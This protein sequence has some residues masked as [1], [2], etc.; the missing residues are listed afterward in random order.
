[1]PRDPQTGLEVLETAAPEE[2]V[3]E[4][5]SGGQTGAIVKA[6]G[7][8]LS[9][10]GNIAMDP[11]QT[12]ELLA[13]MQQMVDDRSGAGSQFMRGLERASAW[14]SGGAEGPARALTAVNAQQQAED[15]SLFNMRQQMA[16]LKSAAAQQQAY[17]EEQ[18]RIFGGAGKPGA[19]TGTMGI[20]AAQTYKG[21]QLDP[22]VAV[23]MGQARTREER[24][25][26]FNDFASKRSQ[27]RGSFEFGA[28]TYQTSIKF[29]RPDGRLE[30][31]DAATAKKYKDMG[32]GDYVVN[33]PTAVA[34]GRVP[35]EA[36]KQVESGGRPGLVSSAGAE[37]T[38]QVMPNTQKNPGYGV[39]PARDNSQQELERVGRD[40]YSAMQKQYGNDTLAS[41][42]YNMGPG[43]TD[44]WLKKG[45]NFKDLPQE[46]RDYIGQV[47]LATAKLNRA[48]AETAALQ[49][50]AATAPRQRMTIPEAEI[51]MESQKQQGISA[52]TAEGKY[53]GNQAATVREAGNTSGERLSS[54]QYLDGLINNPE[55]SRVF[56]VF[57]KPGF[58]NGIGNVIQKGVNLGRLGDVGIKELDSLVVANMKNATQTEIDAAQK[59]T[60]E[61]AKIK[62]NEAK[63]LLAG[64]GAV[65]DAERGLIQE[66]SG[67]RMNSP[68]A[69]RDYLAWGKMRAEYDRDVGKAYQTYR[70]QNRGGTF[71]N[72]LDTGV[73]DD[74]RDAYNQKLMDFGAKTGID[75]N[76]AAAAG[77]QQPEQ[78]KAAPQ[79][80][81]SNDDY[82]AWKKSKG[83]K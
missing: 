76:K 70:R 57:Q 33:P 44:S 37:G 72:F 9:P 51:A 5:A 81:Y 62:L 52:A 3:N 63:I 68:G 49:P 43:A 65:S 82:A 46:T 77:G 1:M 14:G 17:N 13:N 25:K 26:I 60:R 66:L 42:A 34:P 16:A 83:L 54:I 20:G 59:A 80:K 50:T 61:F 45:G 56:G 40:Y 58:M 67:S 2:A 15:T 8:G 10:V 35:P 74:L 36:I 6:T 32:Y 31:I 22:E 11:T 47:H 55:T 23:A 30:Y 12:A 28:P 78:P 24:D 71:E 73:A 19:T 41:I 64:Q 53:I 69:L 79:W 4:T 75:M 21:I 7:K 39:T 48:P 29:V 27:A 38:M 18:A